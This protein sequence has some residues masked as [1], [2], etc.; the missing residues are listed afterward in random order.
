MIF[1]VLA[2]LIAAVV[3][4]ALSFV[5]WKLS[6]RFRLY[7]KI[8][9]RD[10][11][12]TPTP[13]LGGIAMFLGI[14]V[15]MAVASQVSWFHLVFADPG[16][17]TAILSA[18]FIIVVI[19]VADDIWD[20]DWLTKLAGQMIAAGL[21]VWQGVQ[22]VTLPVGGVT[23]VPP[24]LGLVLTVIA[25]VAVMN[26]VNFIDGLDGLVAGVAIIANGVF[27]LYSYILARVVGEAEYF[28]L[29]SLLSA[30]LV[31]AC[32]G[33]LPLNWHPAKL[34]MGDAGSMLVGLL[35]A[36]SAISVTGQ[37]DPNSL[38]S[39]RILAPAFIP[40]LLPIAVLIVP[41]LDFSLAVLRR[42]RAGKSPFSADR[43]HLHHRLLDMGHTHLQAVL[44]FYAWSAVIA[45]GCLLFLFV[46]I[47][48]VLAFLGI[49]FAVCAFFTITPLW[50]KSF[51]AR[52][53]GA[54]PDQ[55]EEIP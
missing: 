7:P 18:A 40:L 41:L 6:S 48:W 30:V 9:E 45:V 42:L 11:H 10:V 49:G 29:A 3:T 8:R 55:V 47:A 15:A 2:G 20:L 35:M 32:V 21:L 39:G 46:P 28:N 51:A 12:T 38:D 52:A 5:I 19:G 1:Y 13:R 14:L 4:F 26:A 33:F 24:I 44:I 23:V 50:R 36:T 53:R 31:G 27:F 16:Q 43:K 34:F 17:I 37:V 22:L 54:H 25:V